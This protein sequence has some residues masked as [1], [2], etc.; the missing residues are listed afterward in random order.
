MKINRY[1]VLTLV[2]IILGIGLIFLS[3]TL[4]GT[5]R[6]GIVWYCVVGGITLGLSPLV[7]VYSRLRTRKTE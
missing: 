3:T 1:D 7:A 2:T 5:D 4:P 6:N